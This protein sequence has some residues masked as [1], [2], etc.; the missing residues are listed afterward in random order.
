MRS[1]RAV[2]S[3]VI[4]DTKASVT[5]TEQVALMPLPSAAVAVIV[6]APVLFAVTVPPEATEAT[7]SS[8]EVQLTLWFP[9]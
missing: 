6:A 7:F 1:P 5:F 4:E 3:R 8:D 2:L 9:A